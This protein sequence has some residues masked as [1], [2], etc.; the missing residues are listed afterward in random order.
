VDYSNSAYTSPGVYGGGAT[1][2]P[3]GGPYGCRFVLSD[4]MP[5]AVE[6]GQSRRPIH[7][8]ER[9]TKPPSGHRGGE[10]VGS[11][12]RLDAID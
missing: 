9:K 2:V 1:T 4:M 5:R 7:G 6:E 10:R 12:A 11:K 3:R 8:G